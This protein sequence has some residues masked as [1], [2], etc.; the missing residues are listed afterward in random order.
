MSLIL[1]E[2]VNG[3]A[4]VTLNN[5]DKLNSF[6]KAM[7]SELQD[8]LDANSDDENVRCIVLTGAGRAFCAGQDLE[9]AIAD[10]APSIGEIVEGHYNPII[11]RLRDIS[12][13][14]IALVNGVAAG[15]GANI[16]YACDIVIAS[17]KASFIQA[18]S[19]IGL[20]PDSGG[21]FTLPRLIGWGRASALMITG[22]KV[23]AQDALNM[24][25]VYKVYAEDVAN[26]ETKKL[27]EQ[28]ATAPT[29]AIG[30]TK[31]ALNASLTNTLEEQ[32]EVEK[33]LQSEA[34]DSYDYKEGVKA[35]LEKRKP[36]FLGK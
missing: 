18:F 10:N 6:N 4:Y 17:E 11:R 15:A 23:L 27:A 13:P 26:E 36:V 24:G 3:V 16:A 5:P 7:A 2:V 20:I 33:A 8:V 28:L 12:K 30:L 22:E 31:L 34:G 1:N 25:M 29:R 32:L 19:K 14:V 35:F 9:E 21:T